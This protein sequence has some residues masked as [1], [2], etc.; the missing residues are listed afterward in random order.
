MRSMLALALGF[1]GSM[2]AWVPLAR[3]QSVPVE[4]FEDAKPAPRGSAKPAPVERAEPSPASRE[5]TLPTPIDAEVSYPAEGKGDHEVVLELVIDSGGTVERAVAVK[6]EPPFAAHAERA[7]QAWRFRPAQREGAPVP[8]T[9]RF[10]VRFSEPGGED[11]SE[12]EK[13]VTAPEPAEAEVGHTAPE[14][15][16]GEP[17]EV[18]VHGE[19]AP[20]T[21][22]LGRAEIRELPGA[23]GDPFRAIE[24]LPG[25]VPIVS[26]LPYFY[27]RGAPPGNVGYYFDGV[28]VPMLYHFAAGPGVLHPSFVEHVDLYP[29]V[30]PVR[31]GRF[32]GGIVAGE[33]APPTYEWRGEAS[34]RL[35]DAGGM[36]EAP[37]DHRQGSAMVGGR[38]SYTALVLSLIVPEVTLQYWDYQSRVR[39]TLDED[40][41]LELLFFGS[42]DVLL[43]DEEEY[44]YAS[45]QSETVT[46]SVVDVNFHRLDLRYDHRLSGGRWRNAVLLGLDSTGVAEGQV[47]FV[48]RLAG[49]RSEIDQVLEPGL[50]LRAGAD[51]LFESLS[52][53]WEDDDG[54]GVDEVPEPDL[55]P[56]TPMPEPVPEP[57]EPREDDEISAEEDFGFDRSRRDLALGAYADLVIDAAPGVEVIPGVRTDLYVSGSD[58]ALGVDPRLMA[59][60]TISEP[61]TITHGVGLAHQLPSFVVPIPGVKPSLVGGLQRALQHS[62]GIDYELPSAVHASFVLF[63]NLFFN[64]TDYIGIVQLSETEDSGDSFDTRMDGRAYGAEIMVSRSLAR[65]LGGFVSYTLSRSERFRGRLEGPATIDRTHVLNV[66]L[67]YDLGKNWRLGNRLLVYSGIPARVAYLEAARH[68]PR[69]PP[70]WRVDWR[71]QKRWPS[72][73]GRGYWGFVAEVLNTLLTKEVLQ[74][75]CNAYE[76]ADESF[77]PVTVPSLG[78]EGAF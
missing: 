21:R 10:L 57:I 74:R 64:L 77:G 33:M 63:H 45:E 19:R 76:C 42:G 71:L 1:A 9:I 40:D 18:V 39:Y 46:R 78:V 70:F 49:A 11:T 36:L 26:G 56:G 22:R 59:R 25:V 37:F 28:P 27:V 55:P 53:R 15:A 4:R 20:A 68:P 62:A 30:Y 31:Y 65:D 7:A 3:A 43:Y 60:F 35:I 50:E 54:S 75:S 13:A 73:D 5:I 32:A 52:Q 66:A 51:A 17:L 41:S 47:R 8:A 24:A 48:N 72:S 61:L 23:F 14:R 58:V 34:V 6:G 69:T 38:Y 2:A 67:S 12:P 29:A 16:R 44:S